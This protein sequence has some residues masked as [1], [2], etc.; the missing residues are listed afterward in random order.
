MST[1]ELKKELHRIIDDSDTRFVKDFYT[2]ITAYIAEN[3]NS[4]M[5]LESE[6][7]IKSGKIHSQSEVKKIIESWKK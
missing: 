1:L 6:D 2:I 3:E 7:D 4:N 5:I